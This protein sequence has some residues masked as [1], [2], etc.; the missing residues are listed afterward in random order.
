MQ[1]NSNVW[2]LTHRSCGVLSPKHSYLRQ[3][4][5]NDHRGVPTR[6]TGRDNGFSLIEMIV[7][8]AVVGLIA[9]LLVSHGPAHSRRLDLNAAAREVTGSLRL[10]RARAVAENRTV[11]WVANRAAFHL[12]SEATHTLAADV[13]MTGS[14][15][16]GFA[17]DGSTSG[18]LITLHSSAGQIAVAVDWLTGRVS[19]EEG[20]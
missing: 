16:I 2:W 5:L 4:T 14:G 9:S 19:I 18:G 3:M 20:G 7:V 11:R 12:D 6:M 17:A 8:L 10:A 1:A 13:T 15:L